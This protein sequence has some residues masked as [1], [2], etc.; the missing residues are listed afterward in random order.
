MQKAVEEAR[1]SLTAF[2]EYMERNCPPLLNTLHETMPDVEAGYCLGPEGNGAS[3]GEGGEGGPAHQEA[4]KI[5]SQCST[6]AGTTWARMRRIGQV[7]HD[8]GGS[9]QTE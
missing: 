3:W 4:G 9:A 2:A 5:S 8:E 6:K 1:F 7:G